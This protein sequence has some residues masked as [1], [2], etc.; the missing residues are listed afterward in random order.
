MS[1]VDRIAELE[2]LVAKLTADVEAAKAAPV[3][4]VKAGRKA[5]ALSLLLKHPVLQTAK[6]AALM[7]IEPK[8]V[9]SQ[10]HYL[11]RDDGWNIPL[12]SPYSLQAND[13]LVAYIKTHQVEQFI[14]DRC[15]EYEAI[16]AYRASKAQ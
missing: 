11:R 7:G 6:L 16:K 8:N 15:D 2:A 10:L 1:K 12:G 9:Q 3:V 13:Q 5:E 14:I 4:V